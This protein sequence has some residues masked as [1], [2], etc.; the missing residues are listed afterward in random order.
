MGG[1]GNSGFR[2]AND[3]DELRAQVRQK[4]EQQEL[5]A[6][7][8]HFLAERLA[9]FNDRDVEST[10]ERLEQIEAAL[11]E[12]GHEVEKLLFGGSVAKHTDVNGLSD[13]DALVFL[14]SSEGATPADVLNS[15]AQALH[16][17]LR[18]GDIAEITVGRM[19]VTVTY[20]DGMEIQLL[21]ATERGS[22]TV[23][24]GEDGAGWRQ[25]RPHK[26]TEKLTEVN[27]STGNGVVPVI[28]L[29]KSLIDKFPREQ[30]LSGYHVEAI[31]VD[32]F[33]SY[34]GP[35]DRASMLNH[36]VERAS[37][38]VQQ[39][40]G[41]ITGQSV[42]IRRALGCSSLTAAQIYCASTWPFGSSSLVGYLGR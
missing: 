24:P 34:D 12:L 35:R 1:S 42:H 38:A 21:P 28:K 26:F 25:V 39:P 19:A 36:L 29:A 13:V 40:T 32:A 15:F 2:S 23:I 7:L 9:T 11:S 17:R 16:R 20:E 3:I 18:M 41:D 4:L 6:D 37:T 14:P 30:Q 8:N 33:R 27:R 22:H 10:R 5:L 31:A